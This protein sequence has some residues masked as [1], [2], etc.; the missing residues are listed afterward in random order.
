MTTAAGS[1]EE[2]ISAPDAAEWTAVIGGVDPTVRHIVA[3]V[4]NA[5]ADHCTQLFYETLLAH[6]EA[7]VFLSPQEVSSRLH[8]AMTRW[9]RNLFPEKPPNCAALVAAQKR[10]GDVHARIRVPMYLAMHG[11]RVI[12]EIL[13]RQLFETEQSPAHLLASIEYMETMIDLAMEVMCQQYTADIKKEIESDEACR[14]MTLGQ[15]VAVERESQR[16]ALLEWGH[17]IL[18][19]ICCA[20]PPPLPRL[21]KSDFG[22]WLNHKGSLLF[23]GMPGLQ[24]IRAI[25]RRIDDEI[26]PQFVPGSPTVPALVQE[27]QAALDEIRFLMDGIFTENELIEGGRDPLTSAL[28]RRFMSTILAREVNQALRRHVPLSVLLLDVD[29]FKQIND[30][31]GHTRG[32]AVLRSVSDIMASV[33]RP[34]DFV[35][36]YGGEEFLIVLVETDSEQALRVA[37]RIRNAVSARP[38]IQDEMVTVSIGV[39]TFGGHPDYE[40]LIREADAALYKAKSAGRDRCVLAEKAISPG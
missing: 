39:T 7:A 28:N 24:N 26:L 11:I 31:F 4:T 16:A 1:E 36:R 32:D 3:T 6:P 13:R 23:S 21:E 25:M 34:S 27:F 9:L 30:Q 38:L 22:L 35:F 37:E 40:Q 20:H 19:A 2:L 15:D 5:H 17:R 8:G 18:V 29:H 33:C 14:L 10:M 12:K